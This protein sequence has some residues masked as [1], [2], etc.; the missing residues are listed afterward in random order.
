MVWAFFLCEHYWKH[1]CDFIVFRSCDLGSDFGFG[2]PQAKRLSTAAIY[3]LGHCPYST[4][5]LRLPYLPLCY[6]IFAIILW[7]WADLYLI[8]ECL[9]IAFEINS[10]M[11]I[12][13]VD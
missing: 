1:C 7:F 9:N 3:A 10:K 8:L 5:R 12:F 4:L 13:V 11:A 2:N 6:S